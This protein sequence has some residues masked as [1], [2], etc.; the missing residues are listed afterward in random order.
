MGRVVTEE[1]ITIESREDSLYFSGI[2]EE[3][4]YR[5]GLFSVKYDFEHGSFP[6]GAWKKVK[7]GKVSFCLRDRGEGNHFV[8]VAF[9]AKKEAYPDY[10]VKYLLRVYLTEDNQL[11]F[12]F[13]I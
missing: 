6:A 13:T 8:F 3:E 9:A 7:D 2:A 10:T 5:Y 1:G 4:S 12:P 11:T